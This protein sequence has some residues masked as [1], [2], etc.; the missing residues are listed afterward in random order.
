LGEI[1]TRGKDREKR[2][3]LKRRG[4]IQ[5]GKKIPPGRSEMG[6]N[7]QE[8]LGEA[9]RRCRNTSRCKRKALKIVRKKK[10]GLVPELGGKREG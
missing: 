1:I 6:K 5:G 10:G 3:E 9:A 2:G 4:V 8:C 7:F